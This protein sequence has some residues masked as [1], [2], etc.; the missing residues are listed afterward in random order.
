M[1]GCSQPLNGVTS[2][3]QISN[4]HGLHRS[5][6]LKVSG[7]DTAVFEMQSQYLFFW[8]PVASFPQ[9]N[10]RKSRF[11]VIRTTTANPPHSLENDKRLH[12][13]VI[14][15]LETCG[16]R[17]VEDAME[18]ANVKRQRTVARFWR[19]FTTNILSSPI[20]RYCLHFLVNKITA[21]RHHFDTG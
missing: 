11:S 9:N 2:A 1:L 13:N 4:L 3:L 14:S 5:K 17:S 20:Q 21:H 18:T 6:P 16:M 12:V 19:N 8:P 7:W 15:V 10:F